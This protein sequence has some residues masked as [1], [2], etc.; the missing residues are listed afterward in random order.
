MTNYEFSPRALEIL[1]KAGWSPDRI[2]PVSPFISASAAAGYEL[3]AA[4]ARFLERFGGLVVRFDYEKKLWSGSVVL[5]RMFH[6]D[7]GKAIR[8]SAESTAEYRLWIGKPVCVIGDSNMG[9]SLLLMDVNGCVYAGSDEYLCVIGESGE[10]AIE[11]LCT[12][13]KPLRHISFP[14]DIIPLPLK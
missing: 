9:N 6:F 5:H 1:T 14:P 7:V 4:A 10:D 2:V 12:R 8:E 11:A 3:H 13:R